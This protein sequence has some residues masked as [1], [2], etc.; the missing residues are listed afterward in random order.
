[1]PLSET[2]TGRSFK[3][4]PD[5]AFVEDLEA[6]DPFHLGRIHKATEE[7]RNHPREF[8]RNRKALKAPVPWCSAATAVVRVGAFRILYDVEGKTVLLLRLGY[9][10]RERLLPVRIDPGDR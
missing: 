7:L 10:V 3:L 6:I 9:K 1:V 5:P 4:A 8:G 2:P